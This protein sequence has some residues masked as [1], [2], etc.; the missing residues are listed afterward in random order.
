MRKGKKLEAILKDLE[1]AVIAFSGGVDSTYLLKK[2]V[3]VLGANRVLAVTAASET[4]PGRELDEAKKLA[5]DIGARHRVIH[6]SELAIKNFS[7]NPPNRCYYCKKELF[8]TLTKI[9]REEDLVWV[10]DGSNFDDLKDHRPGSQAAL[11]LGVRSPLKEAGMT[12][13]E[14]RKSSKLLGL[15]T[16]SKPAFACLSSRFPYGQEITAEKLGQVATAEDFL[17]ELGF[18]QFRVRHHGSVA[19]IEVLPA[20]RKKALQHSEAIC[21]AFREA[22][23]KYAALDLLGY[24]QGSMNE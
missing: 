13:N 7:K 6:T 19:R 1:G 20:E 15:S 10:L 3:D 4:Y 23:F 18:T 5:C 12:K 14:I 24:R 17:S 21:R 11:E 8:G 9:A 2:A 22:G 16:W